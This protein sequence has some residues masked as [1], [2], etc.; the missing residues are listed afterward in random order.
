MLSQHDFVQTG[1]NLPNIHVLMQEIYAELQKEQQ[2]RQLFYE[3]VDENK[4]MEFINGEIIFHSPVKKRHNLATNLLNILLSIYVNMRR[5]GFVGIEKILISL[6]RN[7]YEPDLVYFNTE[8]NQ[9]LHLDQMRFPAPDLA[10]EV[11]SKSTEHTDRT[12]KMD[13]YA[14]HGIT[15]YWII[16][17]DKQTIE[18]YILNTETHTYDLQLK[19]AEGNI[20]S[21]A[22]SGFSIPIKAIFDTQANLETMN[23][24]IAKINKQ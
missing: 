20:H 19:A 4:K 18:Q 6:T 9:T 12:T 16:D 17:P 7:D 15:E 2:Q 13:D 1:L 5:I 22:V 14:A 24:I 10:V 8:K 23:D 21:V 3:T 11:L